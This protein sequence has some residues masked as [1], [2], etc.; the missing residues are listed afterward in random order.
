DQVASTS[1]ERSPSEHDRGHGRQKVVVAL[2]RSWLI[3]DAGMQHRCKAVQ[4]LS[5]DVGPG[6]MTFD[7]EPCCARS[8]RVGADALESTPR[9]RQLD[10]C[11][12]ERC[13]RNGEVDRFRDAQELPTP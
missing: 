2:V 10:Y 12:Y 9:R 6:P 11:R 7:P 13:R 4:N 3:D 5:P 8:C 1:E